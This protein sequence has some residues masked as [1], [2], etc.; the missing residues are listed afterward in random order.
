[1]S[2]KWRTDKKHV[3]KG[4]D[5]AK[6]EKWAVEIGEIGFW[7]LRSVINYSISSGCLA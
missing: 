5:V 2:K 3:P 6:F 4:L 7:D 1:M